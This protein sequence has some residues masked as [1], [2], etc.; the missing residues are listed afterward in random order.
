MNYGIVRRVLGSLLLVE[1][2]LFL[3]GLLIGLYYGEASWQAMG[4]SLIITLVAGG[5]LVLSSKHCSTQVRALDGLLIVSLGWVLVSVFGSLPF[6]FS[7]FI[8]R[9]VDAFFETVSGFTTTGATILPDVEVLDKGIQFWRIFTHWIGGMGILVFSLALLPALGIGS[10]QIF[11]AE[12]P[13]PVA[14]KIAPRMKNTARILYLTYFSLTISQ[15]ILLKLG[16]MT[17]YEATVHSFSTMGT[18][19]FGMYNDSVASFNDF[20][21]MTL[22]VF[23]VLAGLNFSL[24]YLAY[25]RKVRDI[26]ENEEARFFL[27]IIAGATVVIMLDL[28]I[29]YGSGSWL[30]FRD[31]FIQVTSIISTT[32]I[33]NH[34]Y[35]A[36]PYFSQM[37]LLILMFV[38]GCAGST[39]G[40]MKVIRVLVSTKLVRRE[41]SKIAH[42]RAYSP[43]K[44]NGRILPNEIVSGITSF[45]SLHLMVFLGGVL[46]ISLEN[47]DLIT[48]ISAV[49]ATLNNV[50]PGL[51]LLGPSFN[52]SF[53]N[54]ASKLFLTLMMLLGRLE[55][56]TVIALLAP[57]RWIDES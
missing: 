35:T 34:D 57:R 46:F 52:Y 16:G 2:L 13:G 39:A 54:D 21:Q 40:G 7:G 23:M 49:A 9:F 18:G 48:S 29:R 10:F 32:G 44:V 17:L 42:P 56:Y 8:P 28:I 50:G 30:A 11:K 12:S 26:L 27:K 41:F 20:L 31:A 4:I 15:I 22:G 36:W 45:L 3:P 24:Y 14:G 19:G 47:Y 25:R 51:A 33:A 38:G 5:L 6:M 55:L 1:A 43:I 37:L 53:F